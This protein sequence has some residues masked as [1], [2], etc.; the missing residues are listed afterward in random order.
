MKRD[1]DFIREI[2]LGIEELDTDGNGCDYT[3]LRFH[4]KEKGYNNDDELYGHCEI[5]NQGGLIEFSTRPVFGGNWVLERPIKLLWDGHDFLATI[6]DP[7][8]WEKVK[9]KIG[10]A[11][12][13]ISFELLK[14]IATETT[15]GLVG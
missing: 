6:R 7:S 11:M 4:L 2:L 13:S 1:M 14:T 5:M 15:K 10:G 12:G 3:P 9:K 8:T